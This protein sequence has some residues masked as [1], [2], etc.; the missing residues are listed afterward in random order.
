MLH[1][2]VEKQQNFLNLSLD[3]EEWK[4]C[5]ALA[6]SEWQKWSG[7]VCT[8][9]WSFN[10]SSVRFAIWLLFIK[11]F[12][13]DAIAA[14][15]WHRPLFHLLCACVDARFALEAVW[16][17]AVTTSGWQWDIDRGLIQKVMKATFMKVNEKKTLKEWQ[18]ISFPIA[19]FRS[20]FR[21]SRRDGA[22]FRKQ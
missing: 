3:M 7:W 15:T 21:I 11:T 18:E 16:P 8:E 20:T 10:Q 4:S 2:L 5:T 6:V 17:T 1:D 22:G 9:V 19:T 13:K 14:P 12:R